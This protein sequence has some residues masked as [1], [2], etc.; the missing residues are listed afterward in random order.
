MFINTLDK[1]PIIKKADGISIR[2][3]TKTIFDFNKENF[4][5][6]TA[7]KVPKE[8]V[9]RPDLISQA[10]YNDTAYT[11]LILKYNGI[12]NPFAIDQDDIILI[13]SL[14]SAQDNIKKRSDTNVNDLTD[15]LRKTYKYID[16]TKKPSRDSRSNDF[17]NRN[18]TGFDGFGE[19]LLGSGGAIGS[20]GAGTGTGG[21]GTGGD[22]TDQLS[23][24]ALPPNIADEGSSQIDVRNGRVYFG[25]T[26]GQSACLTNGMTN[27]E[28]LTKVIKSRQTIETPI[29]ETNAEAS[30][31]K[32]KENIINKR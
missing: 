31:R 27:S 5:T 30:A 1:K 6:Y 10:V 11:E 16:P 17:D 18:L 7:Y 15:Q 9:M 32:I 26:I 29:L 21:D 28:F 25:E 4:V 14:D 24:G 12:S 22:G 23:D 8:Y 3:L 2:D 20:G 19:G 13:P